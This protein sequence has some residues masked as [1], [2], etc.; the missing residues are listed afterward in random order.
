[1]IGKEEEPPV[2]RKTVL[3]AGA[4]GLIGHATFWAGLV[5][6][7]GLQK[8]RHR[9]HGFDEFESTYRPFDRQFE[10]LRAQLIIPSH[11]LGA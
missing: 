9:E 2:V 5:A 6:R 10:Q 7:Y 3:I 4:H 8:V 11:K 1:M